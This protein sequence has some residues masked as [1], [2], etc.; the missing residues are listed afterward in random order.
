MP[1]SDDVLDL[2]AAD[3]SEESWERL[4]ADIG[5]DDPDVL[6]MMQHPL[7]SAC[8]GTSCG[9]C[10]CAICCGPSGCSFAVPPTDPTK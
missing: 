3:V 10:T 9:G 8:A 5:G 4:V 1:V 2:S 7:A 6:Y